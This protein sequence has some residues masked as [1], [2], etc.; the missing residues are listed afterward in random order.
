MWTLR[1]WVYSKSFDGIKSVCLNR[2]KF[3][4]SHHFEGKWLC[5]LMTATLMTGNCSQATDL[6]WSCIV[7]LSATAHPG[8]QMFSCRKLSWSHN[9]WAKQLAHVSNLKTNSWCFIHSSDWSK[10]SVKLS[11]S[12]HL[13]NAT[14]CCYSSQANICTQYSSLKDTR[15]EQQIMW[16]HVAQHAAPKSFRSHF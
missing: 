16:R 13:Q 14:T 1:F 5:V 3:K 12:E 6:K 2:I 9:C 4:S 11:R 7:P 8:Q 10:L 15:V